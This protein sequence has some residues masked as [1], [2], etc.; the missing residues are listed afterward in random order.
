[1]TKDDKKL[2][3]KAYYQKNKDKLSSRRKAYYEAN[4]EREAAVNNAYREANPEKIK[5]IR[6]AYCE[7]KKEENYART[8]QWRE[9]NK[10]LANHLTREWRK[11]NPGKAKESYAARR[12]SEMERTPAWLNEDNK[13]EMRDMY[14]AAY[15]LSKVFPYELQVDH[16][17]PLRG[18]E[19]SGLHVPWNL[20]L[21][22]AV[23]NASKSNK[24]LFDGAAFVE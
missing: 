14:E 16:M 3:R 7:N 15:E 6:V 8:R 20:Q 5:A 10:D 24:L 2:A 12:A 23:A 13:Q 4:K 18:K 19:V 17:I 1:M 11:N 21:L 22:P 9:A